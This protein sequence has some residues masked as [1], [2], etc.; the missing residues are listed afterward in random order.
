MDS[1]K[2]APTTDT[3]WQSKEFR[4]WLPHLQAALTY[5]AIRMACFAKGLISDGQ[6]RLLMATGDSAKHNELL[7]D[8]LSG[9]TT[10]SFRIF[11]DIVRE[12]EPEPNFTSFLKEMQAMLNSVW[13]TPECRKACEEVTDLMKAFPMEA[14]KQVLDFAESL[15]KQLKSHPVRLPNATSSSHH[16]QHTDGALRKW[17]DFKAISILERRE[18][19]KRIC[20]VVAGTSQRVYGVGLHLLAAEFPAGGPD[21]A[22]NNKAYPGKSPF[23]LFDAVT[24]LWGIHYEHMSGRDLHQAVKSAIGSGT[25]KDVEEF[26]I[27]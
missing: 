2:A 17:V 25:A 18:R 19:L 4:N 23:E 13:V 24:E 20:N 15:D 8:I 10:E 6:K 9:G 12:K 22:I 3:A 5:N 1:V 11:C 21:A 27:L 7:L 16:E 26:C 14:C